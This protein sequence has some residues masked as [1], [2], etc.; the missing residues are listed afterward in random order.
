MYETQC[1]QYLLSIF[2]N[3]A[4]EW[5]KLTSL[6]SSHS[7][8]FFKMGILKNFAIFTG[9]HL[10]WR[11]FLTKLQAWR[12]ETLS[13]SDSTTAIFMWIFAKF[14]RTAFLVLLNIWMVLNIWNYRFTTSIHKICAT[15]IWPRVI[16]V[17]RFFSKFS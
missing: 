6:K 12:P 2:N 8:M 1:E 9:R 5:I 4:L 17:W 11:L 14:L 15:E 13:E 3:I 16:K 10:C 7:Q